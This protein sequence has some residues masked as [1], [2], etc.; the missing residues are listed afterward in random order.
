[1]PFCENC[2]SEIRGNFCRNC[3]S[4]T[5][6]NVGRHPPQPPQS[7]QIS[8]QSPHSDHRPPSPLSNSKLWTLA[9]IVILIL[10]FTLV[11]YF[12]P[13]YYVRIDIDEVDNI[14]SDGLYD[15]EDKLAE[16]EEY[17]EYESGYFYVTTEK[18]TER[19][20]NDELKH[21][22]PDTVKT[23]RGTIALLVILIIFIIIFLI[24]L[25]VVSFKPNFGFSFPLYLFLIVLIISSSLIGYFTLT[26]GPYEGDTDSEDIEMDVEID[27]SGNWFY[28][29]MTFSGDIEGEGEGG[30]GNGYL[31]NVIIL[32]LSLISLLLCFS[33]RND[34]KRLY[35]PNIPFQQY[36]SYQEYP[37]DLPLKETTVY[38][39][40]KKA[41]QEMNTFNDE[42]KYQSNSIENDS[43]SEEDGHID[44]K[45]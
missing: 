11:S 30:V 26:Y 3:G 21:E 23:K 25:G 29:E 24:S 38:V 40:E 13:W 8:S 7:V 5:N 32:I 2:G 44:W 12:L 15:M 9:I 4:A 39:R 34:F 16:R 14:D 18:D 31:L 42:N 36:P 33:I 22:Y 45:E 43:R 19:Y 27:E 6:Y 1:M 37:R 20:D 28:R 41:R 35:A 17:I 10:I